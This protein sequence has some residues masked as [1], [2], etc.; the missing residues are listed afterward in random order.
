MNGFSGYGIFASPLLSDHECQQ[1]TTEMISKARS[2]AQVNSAE[3]PQDYE[4]LSSRS[5]SLVSVSN[6]LLQYST[7]ALESKRGCLEE[8]FDRKL[9][10]ISELSFLEYGPGDF[11]CKHTDRGP[12]SAST[13][14]RSVSTVIFLGDHEQTQSREGSFSGGELLFHD[15]LP[16]LEGFALPVRGQRG[17]LVAFDSNVPH[18]VTKVTAG[19]RQTIVAWF[20]ALDG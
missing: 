11:F 5:T 14:N 3:R 9:G 12:V 20:Q 15:P 2:R 19:R 17:L 10:P 8:F 6:D 7:S 18:E 13:A 16:G 4:D 1:V